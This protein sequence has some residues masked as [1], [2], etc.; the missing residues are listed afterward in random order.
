MNYNILRHLP[1]YGVLI[2]TL[3]EDFHA[4]PLNGMA[5]HFLDQHS[6]SVNKKQRAE[7]VK[8][9]RTF[10]NVLVDPEAIKALMP[11]FEN[12]PIDGLS[13]KQGYQCTT[14]NKLVPQLSSM[15]IHC[16]KHGWQKDKQPDMWIQQY[17]QVYT[18]PFK[19][20]VTNEIDF[21][22]SAPISKVLRSQST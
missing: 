18:C 5:A 22:Y 21:L 17:M 15:K 16:R 3:C 2:C 12:G 11:P 7:L 10:T 13:K 14:C 6:N 9:A 8:Y 4:V 19:I 20:I 1:Q